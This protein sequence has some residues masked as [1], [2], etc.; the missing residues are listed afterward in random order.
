MKRWLTV[1]LALA[2]VI[3]MAQAQMN[4]PGDGSGSGYGEGGGTGPGHGGFVIPDEWE[5]PGD[6]LALREQ[7]IVA[8]QA[9]KTS[10]DALIA[11]LQEQGATQDEIRAAV[12][13]WRV[14]NAGEIETVRQMAMEIRQWFRENRPDRPFPEMTQEMMQ[15]RSQFRENIMEVRQLRERLR[16]C[17]PDSEECDQL[18]LQLREKLQERK[19]L[20]RNRRAGE[21][22]VGG[23]RRPGAGG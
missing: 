13:A 23:D 15:R 17:D 1:F 22:G 21:G 14:E 10:R 5:I 4:G 2:V 3:P 9:L 7:L 11:S 8:R 19:T 12:E 20:M 6:I 16:T 18:R